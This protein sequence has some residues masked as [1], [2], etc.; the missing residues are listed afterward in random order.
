[1]WFCSYLNER[2]QFLSIG[3]VM[4]DYKQISCVLV[5]FHKDQYLDH[6]FSYLYINDF[7]NSSNQL[8]FHLFGDDSNLFYDQKSLKDL[9][10]TG[11]Q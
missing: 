1:M 7:N 6:F 11:K 9:E 10:T 8:D 4:S 3:N 5:E 2:K